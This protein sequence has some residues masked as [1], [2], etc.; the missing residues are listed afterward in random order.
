MPI[1]LRQDLLAVRR[2]RVTFREYSQNSWRYVKRLWVGQ[3]G[4]KSLTH[5]GGIVL[6]GFVGVRVTRTVVQGASNPTKGAIGMAF[7]FLLRLL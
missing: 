5:R 2:R 7:S 1:S 6:V 3:R 4:P